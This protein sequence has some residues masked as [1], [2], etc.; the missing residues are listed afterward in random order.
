MNGTRCACSVRHDYLTVREAEIRKAWILWII[1]NT[2]NT[3]DYMYMYVAS[4]VSKQQQ[5]EEWNYPN[6]TVWDYTSVLVYSM[7]GQIIFVTLLHLKT[8]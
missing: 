5:N 1:L 8:Q 2:H 7:I 3:S 6:N 4:F